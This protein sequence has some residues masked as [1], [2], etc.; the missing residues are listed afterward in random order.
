MN[1]KKNFA[2]ILV[3]LFHNFIL[4]PSW[5]LPQEFAPIINKYGVEG[6]P[7]GEGRHPGIDY[8]LPI[9]TPIVAVSDGIIVYVGDD[10][11]D[12]IYGG[13]F[14]VII[15]HADSFFSFYYHLSSILVTD[16]EKIKRGK[17]IGLSGK[18]NNGF[19]H[20]HFGLL[21]NAKKGSGGKFSQSYNPN[22]YWLND[23]PQCFN[24]QYDYS[25]TSNKEI[26]FPVECSD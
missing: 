1:R 18:S 2:I 21:K 13:G 10:Y 5:V 25:R 11:K 8:L 26:T 3:F 15:K 14:G 9:G 17:R 4:D 16:G 19:P 7:Y 6:M 20:L 24:P 23:E 22:N 12:E